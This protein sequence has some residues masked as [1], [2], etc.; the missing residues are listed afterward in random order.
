MDRKVD[1]KVVQKV[2]T[3]GSSL[4]YVIEKKTL[5]NVDF[6]KRSLKVG[7]ISGIRPVPPMFWDQKV[8]QKVT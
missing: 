1:Q 2:T 5:K 3:T 8:N 4:L 7:N 6:F